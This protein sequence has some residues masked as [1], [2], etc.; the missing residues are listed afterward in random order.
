MNRLAYRRICGVLIASMFAT[1]AQAF[2]QGTATASAPD[3]N[4]PLADMKPQGKTLKGKILSLN[5][6]GRGET[7]G[8]MLSAGDTPVQINIPNEMADA[9]KALHAGDAVEVT[10]DAS[11]PGRGGPGGP[12]GAGGPPDG[13]G[14]QV[15]ADHDV[16]DAQSLTDAQGKTY[17]RPGPGGRGCQSAGES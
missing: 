16:Y 12:G 9:L 14:A 7:E 13:R 4:A 11:G 8:F 2:A 1:S 17:S 5:F 3:A 6:G 15:P 10:V